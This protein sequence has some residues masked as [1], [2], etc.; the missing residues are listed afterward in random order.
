[1]ER[2]LINTPNLSDASVTEELV[3]GDL[4]L[5]SS[6]RPSKTK[7]KNSLERFRKFTAE[8]VEL[9]QG[10]FNQLDFP[11]DIKEALT[12]ARKL[13]SHGARRRQMSFV[14]RLVEDLD[15]DAIRERVRNLDHGIMPKKSMPGSTPE[16]AALTEV[17]AMAKKLLDG[18][19]QTIFALSSR[20]DPSDRQSLRHFLRKSKKSLEAGGNR[21]EL[22]KA[23]ASFLGTLHASEDW[24]ESEEI[25]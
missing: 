15:I 22:R 9:P 3:Q 21:T 11:E 6:S 19:D 5:L 13:T 8:M 20:F 16:A 1:M 7:L 12:M 14:A 23:L 4:D 18:N 2:A 17:E 10:R 24:E 25:F